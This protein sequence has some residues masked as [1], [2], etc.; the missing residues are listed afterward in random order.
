MV[1]LEKEVKE[2]DV[3][4]YVEPTVQTRGSSQ[5]VSLLRGSYRF[6]MLKVMCISSC[7]TAVIISAERVEELHALEI[8]LS[9]MC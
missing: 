1:F 5:L 8:S 4:E 7:M 6:P 2:R 3:I 9:Y